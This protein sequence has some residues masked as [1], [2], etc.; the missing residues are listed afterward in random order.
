MCVI[1]S[2]GKWN[3]NALL[4]CCLLPV[5]VCVCCSCSCSSVPRISR[6]Y[7]C[8]PIIIIISIIFS[9]FFSSQNSIIFFFSPHFVIV[10]LCSARCIY[11]PFL[12]YFSQSKYIFTIAYVSQRPRFSL[13]F[14]FFCVMCVRS[15]NSPINSSVNAKHSTLMNVPTL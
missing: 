5:A 12:L 7:S 9:L 3:L 1:E 13:S 6:V 8:V 4:C 11:L 15:R 2:C 10:H 14:V